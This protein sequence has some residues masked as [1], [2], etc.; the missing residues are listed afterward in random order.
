MLPIDTAGNFYTEMPTF[1]PSSQESLSFIT[2][3]RRAQMVR[4]AVEVI[5]EQGFAE[6]SLAKI[7]RRAGVSRGV[8]SYHFKDKDD[9]VDQV[10]STFYGEAAQAVI[11]RATSENT[12]S[13]ALRAII[14]A[15]LE[16]ISTHRAET[17]AM[18][19]IVA[20]YRDKDGRRLE[21][22]RD[23]PAHAHQALVDLFQRGQESGEFRSFDPESMAIA[24]RGAIDGV[25]LVLARNPSFDV[26]THADEL[27]RVFKLATRPPELKEDA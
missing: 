4:C 23:E 9:L 27:A 14:T 22:M 5:A 12:L 11:A 2:E 21:N 25:I 17:L 20:N 26:A 18:F 15:N 16:F 3:A 19:E 24:V 8:I 10:V 1:N 13:G 6:A 7:A